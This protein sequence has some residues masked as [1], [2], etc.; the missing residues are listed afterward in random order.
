MNKYSM[1]M[2]MNMNIGLMNMKR[3]S[4]TMNIRFWIFIW[5]V[6]TNL[7]E[8]HFVTYF[9]YNNSQLMNMKN[10]KSM[11]SWIW[12]WVK[13]MNP[14]ISYI[15][16]IWTHELCFGKT[17]EFVNMKTDIAMNAWIWIWIFHELVNMNMDMLL[18]ELLK[19]H[20]GH[21]NLWTIPWTP[22]IVMREIYINF[23]YIIYKRIY[24][25]TDRERPKNAINKSNFIDHNWRKKGKIQVILLDFLP[26]WRVEQNALSLKIKM[27]K[28]IDF[29]RFSF[30]Y[31]L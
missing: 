11:N 21:E 26:L 20:T 7:V 17:H 16:N 28:R 19:V 27:A 29:W 13:S 12:I 10:V 18:Y 6:W 2:N 31:G 24:G 1:N 8:V 30:S 22:W 23:I 15:E 25:Y 9:F 3:Q 5:T 4:M 14:W